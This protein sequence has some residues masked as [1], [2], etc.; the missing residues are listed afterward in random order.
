MQLHKR[1]YIFLA[2]VMR[3]ILKSDIAKLKVNGS[4]IINS[5]ILIPMCL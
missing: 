3:T 1:P 4:F 5:H 2:Q